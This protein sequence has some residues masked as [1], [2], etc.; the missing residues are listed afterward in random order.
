MSRKTRIGR[1]RERDVL[2]QGI[3]KIC[4]AKKMLATGLFIIL[5]K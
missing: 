5:K 1:E 4:Y 2:L 3:V